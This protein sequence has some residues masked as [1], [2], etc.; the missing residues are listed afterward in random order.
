MYLYNTI[1]SYLNAVVFL[2]ADTFNN[3]QLNAQMSLKK[4]RELLLVECTRAPYLDMRVTP[5]PPLRTAYR[6][7][8]ASRTSYRHF[9]V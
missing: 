2:S 7:I 9:T 6:P 1:S 5:P 4:H 3:A 8:L